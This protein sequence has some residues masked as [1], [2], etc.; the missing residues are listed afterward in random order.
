M[1]SIESKSESA[2]WASEELRFVHRKETLQEELGAAMLDADPVVNPTEDERLARLLAEQRGCEVA[3]KTARQR[4]LDAIQAKRAA[5]IKVLQDRRSDLEKEQ[6]ALSAKVEKHRKALVELLGIEVVIVPAVP[7][8]RSTVQSLGFQIGALDE[9][10]L[11][12]QEPLPDF[13]TID[14]MNVTGIDPLIEALAAFEGI[15]PPMESVLEWAKACEPVPG[16]TFQDLRRNICLVWAAGEIDPRQSSIFV[17]ALC[18]PGLIGICSN[19]PVGLHLESGTF[20]AN[21]SALKPA[22][23]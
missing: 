15:T 12:L 18:Q 3:M 2:R 1:Q 22:V 8:Q 14:L 16:E 17:E 11:R 5:E 4:R 6:A 13:G 20:R 21:R 19:R 9:K 7:S 10:M 23:F